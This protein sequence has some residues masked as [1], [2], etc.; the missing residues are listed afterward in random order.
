[1]ASSQ[2]DS[3]M[4]T[5]LAGAT[6]KEFDVC[7]TIRFEDV[8]PKRLLYALL[9]VLAVTPDAMLLRQANDFGG[10]TWQLIFWRYLGLANLGVP[11]VIWMSGGPRQ[12]YDG[13]R[14]SM[15]CVVTAAMIQG[16]AS[17]GIT[18][19][20]MGTDTA[21]AL[22]L[23]SLTPIWAALL[24]RIFLKDVLPWRTVAL[25]VA[26][27][28]TMALVFLIPTAGRR[29]RARVQFK[30]VWRPPRDGGGHCHGHL[31]DLSSI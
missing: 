20:L 1:M 7:S 24:S 5:F 31:L 10:S 23:V 13:L 2:E 25:L 8:N 26:G 3:G 6:L 17:I 11:I 12:V 29:S 19:A 27:M 21:R 15:R 30:S 22:T 16:F 18:V 28:L 14:S 9:G 4:A